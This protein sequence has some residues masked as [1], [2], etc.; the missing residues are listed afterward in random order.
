M[1][2]Y[3]EVHKAL[4]VGCVVG[5]ASQTGKPCKQSGPTSTSANPP[6]CHSFFLLTF[7]FP[8][9][10]FLFPLVYRQLVHICAY[11]RSVRRIEKKTTRL[12]PSPAGASCLSV[13]HL[14]ASPARI[15]SHRIAYSTTPQQ[16]STVRRIPSRTNARSPVMS[17]AVK[18]L[19]NLNK[20]PLMQFAEKSGVQV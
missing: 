18:W 13:S 11:S 10:D 8:S 17:T 2:Y 9:Q 20:E 15:A 6:D 16:Y 5:L 4:T 19:E 12:H 3:G 7:P 1:K 14:T